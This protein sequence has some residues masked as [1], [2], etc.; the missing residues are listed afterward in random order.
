M[1]ISSPTPQQQIKKLT[2]LKSKLLTNIKINEIKIEN[3]ENIISD[4]SKQITDMENEIKQFQYSLNE[5]E[6]LSKAKKAIGLRNDKSREQ[7]NFDIL[8]TF[9]ESLKNNL[10]TINNKIEELKMY[11]NVKDANKIIKELGII[12][13]NQTFMDN[14]NMILLEGEKSEE[15]I[16]KAEDGN[17]LINEGI[18]IP[19]EYLNQIL[20]NSEASKKTENGGF[21]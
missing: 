16:K 9:N 1:G 5:E 15:L 4:F 6:K 7:K 2:Q 12:D 19:K 11:I 3:S 17:S 14:A 10:Q 21:Y 8:Y 18:S 13:T 20:G